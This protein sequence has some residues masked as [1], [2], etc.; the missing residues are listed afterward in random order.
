MK[1]AYEVLRPYAIVGWLVTE[2]GYTM[3]EVDALTPF[4]IVMLQDE[5]DRFYAAKCRE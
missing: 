2:K 3:E 5:F 1:S 4:Q